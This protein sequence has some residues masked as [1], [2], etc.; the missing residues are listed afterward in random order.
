MSTQGWRV[1]GLCLVAVALLMVSSAAQA[2]DRLPG[3]PIPGA[4]VKVG[5]K[6]PGSGTIVAKGT[7]DVQGNCTFKDLPPGTYFLKFV[8]DG[9]KYKVS[10]NDAGQLIT[11]AA[12]PSG[13]GTATSRIAVMPVVYTKNLGEVVVTVEIVGNA[14]SSNLN[15]SKSNV[16]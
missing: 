4:S 3:D 9:K 1:T 16:D 6:P 14:L 8:V 2:G 5:R 11:V 10:A 13:N 15:L 7:T 12:P